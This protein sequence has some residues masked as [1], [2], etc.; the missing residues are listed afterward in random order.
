MQP[1][2]IFLDQLRTI[3]VIGQRAIVQRQLWILLMLVITAALLTQPLRIFTKRAQHWWLRAADHLIFPLLLLVGGYG[4]VGFFGR[5]NQP[6]ALIR[7]VFFILW[8]TL[9][10]R[11]FT[12]VLYAKSNSDK[13]RRYERWLLVPL[14]VYLFSRH[15]LLN[16]IGSVTLFDQVEL[17]TVFDSVIT[18]GAVTNT[19]I[20][21][22]LSIIAAW[23]LQDTLFR[24]AQVRSADGDMGAF[25]SVA[26]IT[27]YAVIGI[28]ALFAL[29]ALGLDLSNLAII[30]GGLSVGLGFGL[31]KVV[32]N[33]VSGIVLL[34]E[35]TLR[36]GDVIKINDEVGVVEKLNIRST[37]VRTY[38]NVE[39]IVPNEELLTSKLISYTKTD[40]RVR[41]TMPVGAGYD[42]DPEMINRVLVEVAVQH[43]DVLKEPAPLSLFR[44]FGDSNLDFTLMAWVAHPNDMGR[45]RNDLFVAIWQHFQE[46]EIEIPFPQRDLNLRRGWEE[47]RGEN[48]ADSTLIQT[49]EFEN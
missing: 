43:P 12:A 13:A 36:L 28:G 22:Y 35:Q 42:S 31:Q 16:V 5:I 21:I 10:L 14:F 2:D 26:T 32:S 47:V 6:V 4:I 29:R 24:A 37:I 49:D 7:N 39:I 15:L 20:V 48:S 33:F 45:V 30:G 41:V 9:L 23:V 18:V 27:R 1:I 11:L 25:H 44:G 40:R 38:D 46:H 8:L 34:F 19:L 17:F 3:W